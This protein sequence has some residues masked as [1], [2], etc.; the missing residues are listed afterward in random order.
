[1]N[2]PMPD[3][4]EKKKSIAYIKDNGLEKKDGLFSAMYKLH[5]AIGFKNICFGVGDCI[6]LAIMCAVIAYGILFA[7][8][9]D[10]LRCVVLI[11]SPLF[12]IAAQVLTAWKDSMTQTAEIK[13]VCKYRPSHITAF[14]MLFFSLASIAADIPVSYAVSRFYDSE[15][16][17]I[18]LLSF[19][20]LFF[21][22]V[23]MVLTLLCFK[24]RYS[25][26]ILPAA[27]IL[28]NLIPLTDIEKWTIFLNSIGTAV[29]LAL[30]ALFIILYIIG[31][32]FLVKKG[33]TKNAYR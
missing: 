18:L 2:I 9:G 19:C 27:W 20:A 7:V 4:A 17:N 30:T 11:T 21:Y 1:M 12:F 32:N 10:H 26:F 33:E 13:A 6:Y 22:S 25:E 15:F 14:R 23:L 8:N 28:L 29:P 31:L 3:E 24:H 5:R 16:W